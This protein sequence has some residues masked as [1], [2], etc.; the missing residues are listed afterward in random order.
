MFGYSHVLIPAVNAALAAFY[1]FGSV[2]LFPEATISFMNATSANVPAWTPGI[3]T[4][5]FAVFSV[6]SPFLFLLLKNYGPA[7]WRR[8][9]DIR[10]TCGTSH[11]AV[12]VPRR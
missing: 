1:L 3:V 7:I 11:Y 6:C 5:V 12:P 10:C 9:K 8:L 4:Y 2:K